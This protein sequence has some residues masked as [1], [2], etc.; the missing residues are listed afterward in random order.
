MPEQLV[1]R[2]LLRGRIRTFQEILL[3]QDQIDIPLTQYFSPGVYL[4]RMDVPAGAL[5]TGKIHKY[6]CMSIVVSGQA[7]VITDTGLTRISAPAVFES[8]AGVKRAIWAITDLI[9]IT[10]H[11][12]PEEFELDPDGMAEVY[13]VETY[14][15]LEAFRHQLEHKPCHS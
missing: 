9:W 2:D 7:D 11:P 1:S 6:P 12:N 8:P 3:A 4:R 14:T 13:T 5:L 15:E 10:V